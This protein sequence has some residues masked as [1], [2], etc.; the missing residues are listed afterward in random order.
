MFKNYFSIALR[1]LWRNKGFSAITIFGLAIGMTT[2]LLITL[3]VTD[4]LSYDRFNKKADRIYRINADFFVNGNAFKERYTPSQLGPV[5]QQ[6]YP[7]VENYVRFIRQGNILVKKGTTTLVEKNACFADSTLFDVFSLQ[8]ISGDPKTALTQPHTMVIS[9]RMALKYFNSTDVVG[10]T[11]QTD[12]VATYQISGVIK[13]V[14]DQSHLHFD[15]VRALSEL[16]ESRENGGW[17]SDNYATY[18]LMREGATGAQLQSYVNA[19]TKKYMEAP[20]QKMTGSNFA[21]LEKSGGHFGYNVLPLTKIHLYSPLADEAE[22]SGNIQY[23]YIFIAVAVIILLIA[24]VNFMNLSTARSAGRAKEVGV[25][26]VL[27]SQRSS[28]IFQFLTESTLTSFFALLL[29]VALAILLLPYL[30]QL[31][32]KH[33]T[34]EAGYFLWLLPFLLVTAGVIGLLAGSYPAFFLSGFEPI[35]VL[36]GRLNSGFK[37]GWLRNSLVVF[38]FASAILLIVG[39]LVINSQLNY[40][41][42][43]KLGYNREQV[44]IL[45]NTQSLWIHARNFKNEVLSMPGVESGTMTASLPTDMSLNTNIYSKDAARSAGQVTGVPEWY[46]DAD[47]IHTMGMQMASGRNFSPTM[48]SDTFAILLNETAARLFGFND[49]NEKYLYADGSRPLKVI[50]VVKDFNAGSLRNKIPPMVFRLRE[51]PRVMAF[52]IHTGNI[53]GLMAKIKSAYEAQPGMSGQPFVY[54]FLDDDFN[55]LYIAE[56]RTGKIFISFAVLAVLIASLGVFGLITYAA[57]QR[58]R[59]IGI[60]KVLGAS[61]TGIV[62]MLSK[63][64][65]KLVLV[66]IVIAS[67][68]AWYM[69]SRWLQNF[70]YQVKMNWTI[71]VLAA[72]IAIAI[73]ILTVSYRAIRAATANPVNS[74]KAE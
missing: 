4:E 72:F 53:Q 49:L 32:G 31:S 13:D 10:K 24:C 63:D 34:L 8:M 38:Q 71:F 30:N 17:M 56:Q 64:F 62:A 46:V 67:P 22:P 42:S 50:G 2:C 9:E 21:D 14:P 45:G 33:I 3:F 60:R 43:K 6:E 25:R 1:N 41:R 54:S 44:L 36:K 12:N 73:T 16:P 5:L 27:G 57:E 29:A 61:V 35:K 40:I 70:A 20:L 52:R 23:V 48:P 65:L 18:V 68:L 26:K 11:L 7:N 59:E 69:M 19:V 74:L 51:N 47:Y 66:A 58:T 39:T 55:R 37:N 28:L 15:F